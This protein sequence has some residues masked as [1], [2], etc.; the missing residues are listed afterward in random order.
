EIDGQTCRQR[1]RSERTV[2]C[3]TNIVGLGHRGNLTTFGDTAGVRQIRLDDCEAALLEDSLEIEATEHALARGERD[4][5]DRCESRI[6]LPLLGKHRLLDEERA[7][8]LEL[9]EEHLRHG[10]RHAPVEIEPEVDAVTEA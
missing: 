8:M 6:V 9:L 7:Q 3:E 5:A 10:N 4:T 2:R 1:D